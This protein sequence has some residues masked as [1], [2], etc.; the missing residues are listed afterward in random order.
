MFVVKGRWG[1]VVDLWRRFIAEGWRGF[2]G[3][4]SFAGVGREGVL[5][6][7]GRGRGFHWGRA[8]SRFAGVRHGRGFTGVG[9]C[10]GF[11]GVY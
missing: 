10:R 3:V 8:W 4:A 5:V 7:V 1:F 6:G 2:A 11:A 9:R